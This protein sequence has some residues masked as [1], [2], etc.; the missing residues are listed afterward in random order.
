MIGPLAI[1]PAV[2]VQLDTLAD[3]IEALAGLGIELAWPD[4]W[5]DRALAGR[6]GYLAGP[7]A[8]RWGVLVEALALQPQLLWMVRGGYGC[9]RTLLAAR[10]AGHDLFAGPPVPIWG[11]S[12]GTALL[13]AWDR[14]GWPAWHAPPLTQI[15][16]LDEPSRARLRAVWHADHVGAF[17]DLEVLVPGE[18]R[19]PLGGGNLCILASLVGTPWEADLRGRLVVIEDTGEK[20]YKVDRLMMQL[21]ASGALA[22]IAGLVIGEFVNVHPDQAAGID[23][24]FEELAP[25]LGVPVVRRLPVGHHEANAPL[26]FGRATGWEGVLEAPAA[27]PQDGGQSGLGVLRFERCG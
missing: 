1:A 23:A 3:G 24:F 5:R 2:P 22:D 15:P 10:E 19:G 8:L 12:D 18:A 27:G 21:K 25:T 7:D 4:G 17:E 9:L 16:R 26:P 13:A 6:V 11:F 14:A 20:A